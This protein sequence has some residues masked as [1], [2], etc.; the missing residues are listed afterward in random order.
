MNLTRHR[1]NLQFFLRRPR[2]AGTAVLA[3][4]WIGATAAAFEHFWQNDAIPGTGAIA[5]LQATSTPDEYTVHLFLHSKCPC[6]RATL[7]ELSRIAARTAHPVAYHVHFITPDPEDR[8]WGNSSLF[9]QASRLPNVTISA[10]PHGEAARHYG[11]RTSGQVVAYR[12]DGSLAYQ[13]GVT[14]SRGHEGDNAG[15]SMLLD[16]LNGKIAQPTDAPVYGCRLP[17]FAEVT[18]SGMPNQ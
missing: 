17:A 4:L 9:A 2:Y 6:S 3:C 7:A 11:A 1:K 12:P 18:T 8:D 15:K 16:A 13:G 14:G 10:D 5:P